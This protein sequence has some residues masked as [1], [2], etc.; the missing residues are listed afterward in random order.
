MDP[1]LQLA[2]GYTDSK[3]LSVFLYFQADAKRLPPAIFNC[4]TNAAA[5]GRVASTSVAAP[6][7][8]VS[9]GSQD[10]TSLLD[11]GA[12]STQGNQ[13][14]VKQ[15]SNANIGSRAQI[16]VKAITVCL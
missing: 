13:D 7:T 15:L 9:E 5:A 6:P 16:A 10:A 1:N 2:Y 12:I 8:E 11:A 3:R 14:G 4:T